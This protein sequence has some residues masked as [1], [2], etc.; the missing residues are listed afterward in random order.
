M[1][2]RIGVA[3]G[4]LLS[5]AVAGCAGTPPQPRDEG[6]AAARELPVTAHRTEA[7]ALQAAAADDRICTHERVIGSN[8]RQRVCRTSA[9]REQERRQA[10]EAMDRGRGPC[11]IGC[12]DDATR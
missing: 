7:E 6:A 10:Q 4:L 5:T 8:L 2:F 9:Q 1:F 11:T 12:S 3:A